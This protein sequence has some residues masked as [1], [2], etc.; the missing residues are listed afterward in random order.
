MK[1]HGIPRR[2]FLG[3]AAGALALGPPRTAQADTSFANFSFAATG[4]PTARTMPDRL[5]DVINV[6]DWGA[7]GNRA[8]NDTRA[9]QA[10]IDYCMSTAGGTKPAGGKVFFPPGQYKY[11]LA[12]NRRLKQRQRRG[13]AHR[14][15]R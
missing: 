7:V 2:L 5:S 3:S 14:L 4:A 10:A 15:R 8:T 11:H 9:V 12:Y 1:V 13:P 6:K